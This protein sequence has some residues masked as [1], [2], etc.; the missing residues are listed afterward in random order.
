MKTGAGGS[1]ECY[2]ARLVAQGFSQKYGTDYNEIFSPMIRLESFRTMVALAV[3][4]GLK[5]HQS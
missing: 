4:Y 5:L 2:K 3:Q 1:V